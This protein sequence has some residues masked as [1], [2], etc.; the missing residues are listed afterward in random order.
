MLTLNGRTGKDSVIFEVFETSPS[1]KDVL[2]ADDALTW[3]FPERAVEIA[4]EKFC[5]VSFQQNL[6]RFLE[7][8]AQ[9]PLQRFAATTVK[10]GVSVIETRDT[11][12]PGLIH[13]FLMSLLAAV[14]TMSNVKKVRKRVRDD[15]HVHKGGL[16]WRRNPVWLA[17]RVTI[18][19]QLYFALGEPLGRVY[20]KFFICAALAQ[21]LGDLPG[22]I[23]P[24]LILLLRAKL[25]RRLAK[26]ETD[27]TNTTDE[28][29]VVYDRLFTSVGALCERIVTEV[30]R[31]VEIAWHEYKI[32]SLRSV[33]QLPLRADDSA[34]TVSL[35]KSGLHLRSLLHH[36]PAIHNYEIS[37][38]LPSLHDGAITEARALNKS[39]F[40]FATIDAE[41]E[42]RANVAV[43]SAESNTVR[44]TQFA[45]ELDTLFD[46]AYPR[47]APFPEQMSSFLLNTF[48]VWVAMDR[49]AVAECP[50][51]IE[52]HPVFP[53]AALDVLLLSRM[54]EMKR[55]Q[56]V[57][58]YL[59][60]RC[61]RCTFHSQTIFSKP[62]EHSFAT[63]YLET[64]PSAH[65]LINLQSRIE[66]DSDAA[67]A[68][69]ER[70]WRQAD[71]DYDSLSAAISA[72]TCICS[73]NLDG[74][75]NVKGCT[76]CYKWRVRNRLQIG[77]HEDY[78]ASQPAQKSA[79]MFELVIPRYLQAYRNATW[80]IFCELGH[81][82]RPSDRPA[83]L[84]LKDCAQL[85]PYL[86]SQADGVSLASAKKSFLQT[87]YKLVRMKASLEKVVLPFAATFSYYDQQSGLWV[88]ELRKPVTFVH[89]CGI[90]IPACLSPSVMLPLQYPPS[91]IDGPTSYETIANQSKCP[92]EISVHEFSALQRLLAGKS[93]RWLTILV[94]L[95]SSNL[96]FSSEDTMKLLS[97]LALQAGPT[98]HNAGI[99]RD[100]H[101]VF[102][103]ETFCRRLSEQMQRRLSIIQSNWREVYCMEL[104]L[105]LALRFHELT[106]GAMRSMASR[107]IMSVRT[108]TL[109]WISRLRNETREANDASAAMR[110]ASYG[111][112][113]ALLCRRTFTVCSDGDALD[114]RDLNIFIQSS[115]ALQENLVIN[116]SKLSSTL[117]AMLIR[118]MKM[119]FRIRGVVKTSI[120]EH[121]T[122]LDDAIRSSWSESQGSP[123][124]VFTSWEFLSSPNDYW[125]RAI[126]ASDGQEWMRQQVVHYNT[127]EGHLLVDGIPLGKLP[128]EIVASEEVREL[129]GNQHLLTFP[130]SLHGMSHVLATRVFGHEIHF[131]RRGDD[132]VIRALG[133]AATLE[134]IPRSIFQNGSV[135][136]LPASLT[137]RCIHWLNLG[138]GQLEIRR[139]PRIWKSR[140]GDWSIDLHSGK[141]RRRDSFLVD[142]HSLLHRQIV[143][144]FRDFEDP[145]HLTVFQPARGKLSVELKRMELS[146]VV[147]SGGI[148]ECRQLRA[149]VDPNQDAGTLYGLA[150]GLVVRDVVDQERRSLIVPLGPLSSKRHG[151]HVKVLVHDMSGYGRFEI[152][153]TL[154]R[155][156]CPA[157]PR[158]LYTKALLHAMTAFPLPDPLTGA[159][160]TEEALHILR[161]GYCRPWK[162]LIP[163]TKHILES[164]ANLSPVRVYYPE[165]KKILQE[166]CWDPDFT[167]TIQH[168]NFK[169]TIAEIL[170]ESDRLQAF[171][172]E[173]D[174]VRSIDRMGD[175]NDDVEDQHLYCRGQI[176]RQIYERRAADV[177]SSDRIQDQAYKRRNWQLV[178][179]Q[180]NNVYQITTLLCERNVA[181][182]V[183]KHAAQ[184]LHSLPGTLIGGFCNGTMKSQGVLSDWI[185]NGLSEQWGELVN[186][187]RK[188][189]RDDIYNTIYH[190]GFLAFSPTA[191]MEAIMLLCAYACVEDLKVLDPPECA[192]F[193]DFAISPTMTHHRLRELIASSFV[194][195]RRGRKRNETSNEIEELTDHLMEQWPG[196]QPD[197]SSFTFVTLPRDEV[198]EHVRL[199]WSHAHANSRL[200]AYMDSVQDVLNL[201][202]VKTDSQA[203][204]K[205][206]SKASSRGYGRL[207]DIVP[208]LSD[209]VLVKPA[210]SSSRYTLALSE[211]SSRNFKARARCPTNADLATVKELDNIVAAFRL[212]HKKLW[213]TY[214]IDLQASLDAFRQTDAEEQ[215]DVDLPDV[216]DLQKRVLAARGY[217][218][219]ISDDIS[220]SLA[221]EDVRFRWLSL[222]QLWPRTTVAT[223]LE[224]LRSVSRCPCGRDMRKLL[225][226]YGVLI[227]RLQWLLRARYQSLIHD[228]H[229]LR[230]EW[231]D[232]GHA[233]WD[234]SEMA[235]WL[236]FEIDNNLL[237]RSEQVE[238]ARA[239]ISPSC[240]SNSVLQL[241]MGRGEH[242]ESH[243]EVRSW[244]ISM[245]MD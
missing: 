107:L 74:S 118:D 162:P 205:W 165:D 92:P 95:G 85:Q 137:D 90:S 14:G 176:R 128:P 82:S 145:R 153:T 77:I 180:E 105:T 188:A 214:G 134:Y 39:C 151:V 245:T 206:P 55:L 242:E 76:K 15:V 241:N 173:R 135:H 66:S 186:F 204:Q 26:L 121:L 75:R 216:T 210:L 147:K 25:C 17:L 231:S 69:K 120:A 5:D 32:G 2:A 10:A 61:E 185:D 232:A 211:L 54:H 68:R 237:I 119:A 198:I 160:G 199:A 244:L 79:V 229:R 220:R 240:S 7:Q 202:P 157:E 45:R 239:I 181:S 149:E 223:L 78:L 168:D 142:P 38:D 22:K 141:V 98:E 53:P 167:M 8:A 224:H 50:V 213:R 49:C 109:G 195:S 228:T 72:G 126:M 106:D 177:D 226:L 139:M 30:T 6:A 208:S 99:L 233:N 23:A 48:E 150:S 115:I 194:I 197:V 91:Y 37:L 70:E 57:Q 221:A 96:N 33:P 130:S 89:H 189:Q 190:L 222:G 234:P 212:S 140:P 187:C 113:A 16:V 117:T 9:E 227:T 178:E 127:I 154:G 3:E 65:E 230:E 97:Q 218:N 100:I 84:M 138:T 87:H 67:R 158:L 83:M 131:G 42:Q 132:I 60:D 159:T 207:H 62:S 209:G 225:V 44:C 164:I 41:N 110:A 169:P 63:R 43:V 148:L 200:L 215:H 59:R 144:M 171:T 24:E 56:K 27:G 201:V 73:K 161:S 179:K 34:I 20:Y 101:R 28:L 94:E 170:L 155:L 122:S 163:A 64:S 21:L 88:G 11:T 4:W 111:F 174:D 13:G 219:A 136:D 193:T 58:T 191:N 51:L 1:A 47:Y 146:F 192:L 29:R 133:Y 35:P 31:K 52:F 129:F 112:W 124:R 125:I 103:D 175:V 123:G 36:A 166:V 108:I 116:P 182:N 71:R 217:I 46:V 152:D 184:I 18:S 86:R 143:V 238:V 102:Q 203:L 40:D 172:E 114:A 19:R 93:R 12:D 104:I 196:D 80:K 156:H 236:L 81:P 235:D 243:N 183:R